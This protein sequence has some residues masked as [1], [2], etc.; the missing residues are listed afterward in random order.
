MIS[1]YMRSNNSI[2]TKVVQIVRH[3]SAFRNWVHRPLR[4]VIVVT[5]VFI[6]LFLDGLFDFLQG[7][8]NIVLGHNAERLQTLAALW[9]EIIIPTI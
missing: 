2:C 5:L 1:F 9:T 3:L 8:T 6:L 4:P 7:V